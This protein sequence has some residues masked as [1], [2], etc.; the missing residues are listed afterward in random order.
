[1]KIITSGSS[2]LSKE[3][4]LLYLN[5]PITII[6]DI[7][8]QYYDFL[9]LLSTA[10]SF[11]EEK[12]LFLGDFVDRG[13]FSIEVMILV[14]AFKICYPK[15]VFL[16]RGNHECRQMTSAFNFRSEC[17]YKYDQDVYEAFVELF[18]AMPI[19]TV[20]NGKFLAVHG[21]LSPE[22]KTLDNINTID[23]FKE[24]PKNGIIKW[25]NQ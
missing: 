2:I 4:N 9:K 25:A 20:I 1:M 17:L 5:D 7:H 23:R 18:A 19:A 15:R 6:G 21:G 11:E 22:L 10:G 13:N 8:G 12:F 16:L 3:P 14:L 24:P